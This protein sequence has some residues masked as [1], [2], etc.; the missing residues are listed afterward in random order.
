MAAPVCRKPKAVPCPVRGHAHTLNPVGEILQQAGAGGRQAIH[1]ECPNGGYR[2][3]WII[4]Y[5]KAVNP[6]E[7]GPHAPRY[8][9]PRWGWNS[10][11]VEKSAVLS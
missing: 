6:A 3:F 1:L 9:R 11:G 10:L 2:W 8:K 4:G 5:T 7:P